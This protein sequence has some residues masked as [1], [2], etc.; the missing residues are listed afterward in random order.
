MCSEFTLHEDLDS[1]GAVL[2]ATLDNVSG[3]ISGVTLA[4]SGDVGY[5]PF[6]VPSTSSVRRALYMPCMCVFLFIFVVYASFCSF[7]F[8]LF[9]MRCGIL[10]YTATRH[11]TIL[12]RKS[13]RM[14]RVFP[15]FLLVRNSGLVKLSG[16][17]LSARSKEAPT[18]HHALMHNKPMYSKPMT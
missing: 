3:D 5:I 2:T 15:R 11:F 17:T 13:G 9:G 18:I 1:S 4:S 12:P 14:F 7:L 8:G 10:V 6:T 16:M